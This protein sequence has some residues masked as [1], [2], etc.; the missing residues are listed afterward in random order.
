[1]ERIIHKMGWENIPTKIAE[2]A[3]HIM[4]RNYANTIADCCDESLCSDTIIEHLAD[5]CYPAISCWLDLY[6]EDYHTLNDLKGQK[7]F[8]SHRES[9]EELMRDGFTISQIK[10]RISLI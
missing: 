5:P 3:I 7:N 9:M 8:L 1:M 6:V 4:V 10:E 2:D